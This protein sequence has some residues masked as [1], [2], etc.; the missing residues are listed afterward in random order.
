MEWIHEERILISIPYF[1]LIVKTIQR[2][3]ACIIVPKDA[4]LRYREQEQKIV[5]SSFLRY[6]STLFR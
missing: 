1:S 2:K 4:H 5:L 6:H 3:V